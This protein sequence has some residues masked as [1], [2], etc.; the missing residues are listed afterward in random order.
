MT[1]LFYSLKL[2][3]AANTRST[4]QNVFSCDF[5]H[6]VMNINCELL[7]SLIEFKNFAASYKNIFSL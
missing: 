4:H 6:F 1:R 3:F 7:S 2:N 5:L